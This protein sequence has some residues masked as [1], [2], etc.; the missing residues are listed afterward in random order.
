MEI[1]TNDQ[2]IEY[3]SGLEAAFDETK[4]DE[5]HIKIETKKYSEEEKVTI[6]T[7]ERK[8]IIEKSHSCN[9]CGKSLVH[10]GEKPF[11]CHICPKSYQS[12]HTFENTYY[13]VIGH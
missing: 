5:T 7:D 3:N 1:N 2:S 4:T 9:E 6:K 8:L 10:T 13:T 11:V 12:H